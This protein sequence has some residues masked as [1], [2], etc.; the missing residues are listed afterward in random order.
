MIGF[1]QT[2]WPL[3]VIAAV[4]AGAYA[5][6]V[7][8]A[9]RNTAY[10][11]GVVVGLMPAFLMLWASLGVGIFGEPDNL[12]TALVLGVLAL[13]ALTGIVGRFTAKGLCRAAF[14]T[15][16]AYAGLVAFAGAVGWEPRLHVLIWPNLIFVALFVISA[17]LFRRSAN[18]PREATI[19]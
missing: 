18:H 16:G 11:L 4:L 9:K 6:V 7:T 2:F 19:A 5:F 3:F 17:L 13:G 12:E 1:L 14:V 8:R 10:K 15:A